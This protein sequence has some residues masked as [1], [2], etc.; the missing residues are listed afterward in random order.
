MK[1]CKTCKEIEEI[2]EIQRRYADGTAGV[3]NVLKMQPVLLIYTRKNRKKGYSGYRSRPLNFCPECGKPIGR[4]KT[5]WQ[6]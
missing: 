5:V 1:K 2:A 6:I 4:G 3:T